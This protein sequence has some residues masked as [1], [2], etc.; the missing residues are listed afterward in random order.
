M[1]DTVLLAGLITYAEGHPLYFSKPPGPL[2][3]G[4]AQKQWA[5]IED[6]MASSTADYLF[7][8]GHYPVFSVGSHGSTPLL[9]KKLQPLLKQYAGTSISGHDHTAQHLEQDGVVYL[10]MGASDECCYSAGSMHEVP[11]G[12]LVYYLTGDNNPTGAIG[13]FMCITLGAASGS[14]T[15]YDQDG[16]VL[17][18]TGAVLAPRLGRA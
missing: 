9:V 10:Q 3:E 11:A 7:V 1:I 5:F 6:A 2:D 16:N 15:F 13:S 17:H 14:A 4:I 12:S 8:A 18:E